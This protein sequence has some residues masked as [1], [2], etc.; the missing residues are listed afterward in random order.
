MRDEVEMLDFIVTDYPVTANWSDAVKIKPKKLHSLIV[1]AEDAAIEIG[2]GGAGLPRAIGEHFALT[3]LDFDMARLKDD[4]EMIIRLKC[5][6]TANAVIVKI[7]D[8]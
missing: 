3:H 8:V 7:V 5:A 2:T 6:A 1:Y 4:D